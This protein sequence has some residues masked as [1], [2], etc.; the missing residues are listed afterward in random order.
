MPR[1]EQAIAVEAIPF[2]PQ[3]LVP[4]NIQA[5][6]D[7]AMAAFYRP[8]KIVSPMTVIQVRP[9]Q[10]SVFP[11]LNPAE[12]INAR[13][14]TGGNEAAVATVHQY[15]F[16]SIAGTPH[17]AE[18]EIDILT[19]AEYRDVPLALAATAGTSNMSLYSSGALSDAN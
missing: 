2:Q 6:N 3:P 7:E 14:I 13:M 15:L 5:I 16:G 10:T 8:V 19:N 9:V 1:L 4:V 11:P 18:E 12:I 17:R